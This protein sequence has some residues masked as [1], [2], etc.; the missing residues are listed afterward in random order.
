M[1]ILK[2]NILF[3]EQGDRFWPLQPSLQCVGAKIQ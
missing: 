2:Q 3:I 1:G